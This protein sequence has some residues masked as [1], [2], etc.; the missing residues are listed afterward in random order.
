[1]QSSPEATWC[2]HGHLLGSFQ[3]ALTPCIP[4]IYSVPARNQALP[5]LLRYAIHACVIRAWP[6]HPHERAGSKQEI[7]CTMTMKACFREHN[8]WAPHRSGRTGLWLLFSSKMRRSLITREVGRGE[9]VR[10]SAVTSS[11]DPCSAESVARA[12]ANGHSHRR[13]IQKRL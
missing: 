1:M 2:Q 3:L 11:S 4:R 9:R 13:P 7:E 6:D 12:P 5:T 10:G 8:S